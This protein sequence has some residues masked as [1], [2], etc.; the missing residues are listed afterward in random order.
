MLRFLRVLLAT[1]QGTGAV[2]ADRLRPPPRFRT[3]HWT[4]R[5]QTHESSGGL[6]P[7]LDEL[8]VEVRC[9]EIPGTSR[10]NTSSNIAKLF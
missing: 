6:Y 10:R 1:F 4:D 7:L 2:L 5:G 9:V 3:V 8:G